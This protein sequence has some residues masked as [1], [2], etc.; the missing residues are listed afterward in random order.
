MK[1]LALCGS[2]RASSKNAQLLR[3]FILI[4]PQNAE[5]TL[6]ET[7]GALPLFNPDDENSPPE[8]VE[9][10]RTEIERADALLIASPEYAHGITGVMKN[11][12]DWLVSFP[13]FAGKVI[14]VLN[15]APRAHHADD[16]IREIL[17]T[18]SARIVA[19]VDTKFALQTTTQTAE[20]IVS[21]Q[22]LAMQISQ[23]FE[24][25]ASC[26]H[27]SKSGANSNEN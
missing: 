3:A 17:C 16:S 25:V 1:I 13:P 10:F 26:I 20:Q 21:D 12:L 23:I 15:A 27:Q 6:C 9:R 8:I 5:I 4:G 2:L 19:D 22:E 14:A 18:M 24:A 11:A 7:I